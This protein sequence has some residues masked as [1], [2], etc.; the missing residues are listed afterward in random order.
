MHITEDNAKVRILKFLLCFL[1][2]LVVVLF[3][4]EVSLSTRG[5]GR[6]SAGQNLEA[7]ASQ[8]VQQPYT[9][10]SE[11]LQKMASVEVKKLV[12]SW[13]LAVSGEVFLA[14]E[15]GSLYLPPPAAVLC[16]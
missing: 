8:E 6:V 2:T 10:F 9:S 7:K 5:E 15:G 12:P 3:I 4:V 1:F 14:D 16:R 11:V 13:E